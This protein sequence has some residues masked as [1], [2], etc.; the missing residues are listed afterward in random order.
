MSL[1]VLRTCIHVYEGIKSYVMFSVLQVY[2]CH[3]N[4]GESNRNRLGEDDGL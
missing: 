2:N 1:E 4:A 3:C